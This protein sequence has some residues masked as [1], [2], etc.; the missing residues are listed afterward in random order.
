[1]LYH[2]NR[3]ISLF[4]KAK[5]SK[6][7]RGRLDDGIARHL[8]MNDTLNK[9]YPC[10]ETR[11]HCS[12]TMRFSPESPDDPYSCD[13]WHCDVCDGTD[14]NGY[15]EG[16]YS[17]PDERSYITPWHVIKVISALLIVTLSFCTLHIAPTIFGAFWFA[18]CLATYF[19]EES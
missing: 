18:F 16:P 17:G 15:W 5:H 6:C 10:P 19:T 9:V 14:L 13:K 2:L 8:N 11:W 1:M 4:L 3:A 12:G 7:L